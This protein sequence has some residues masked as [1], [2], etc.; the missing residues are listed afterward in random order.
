MGLTW[1]P[2]QDTAHGIRVAATGP[3]GPKL[4]ANILT[5]R[6]PCSPATCSFVADAPVASAGTQTSME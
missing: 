3:A 6:R 1:C 2:A 5:R 4:H